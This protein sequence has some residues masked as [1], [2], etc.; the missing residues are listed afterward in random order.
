MR[1]VIVVPALTRPLC[2]LEPNLV[3]GELDV[4][5]AEHD[6]LASVMTRGQLRQQID[7]EQVIEIVVLPS[8]LWFAVGHRDHV[9]R[10][11]DLRLG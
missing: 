11:F 5:V 4:G 10:R 6:I 2:L 9:A 1:F 8:G 3:F 7:R